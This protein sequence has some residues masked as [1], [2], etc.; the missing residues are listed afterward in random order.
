MKAGRQ[1][2][3]LQLIQNYEINTQD[4][5]L[6]RLREE[7]FD[8]TQATISRDIKELRIIK[9]S[10]QTENIGTLPEKTVEKI[11]TRNFI[12]CLSIPFFPLFPQKIWFV[13]SR[14]LVW[15]KRFAPAMDSLPWKGV[16]GTIAGDDTIFVLCNDNACA[17]QLTQK[18]CEFLQD[19]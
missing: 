9:A 14:F 16:V 1:T 17:A 7:G 10:S 8:V 4:E 5:L 2:K 12:P 6:R 18:L 3:I 15:H 11:L 19:R 13:L